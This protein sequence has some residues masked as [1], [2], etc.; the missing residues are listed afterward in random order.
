MPDSLENLL[1]QTE[2]LREVFP[3]LGEQLAKAAR[4]LELSGRPVP[5][6]LLK[7]C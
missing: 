2:S 5:D 1:Q 4:R 7:G 3:D 6:S